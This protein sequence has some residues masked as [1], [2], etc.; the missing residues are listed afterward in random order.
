MDKLK[1]ET[2]RM[3]LQP[4]S[5]REIEEMMAEMPS[6][7]MSAPFCSFTKG[8]QKRYNLNNRHRKYTVRQTETHSCS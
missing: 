5:D 4:M 7:Y 3:L 8:R 2:K 1:V 6:G